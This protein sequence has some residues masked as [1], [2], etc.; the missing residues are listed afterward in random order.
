MR[1]HVRGKERYF[2]TN[3]GDLALDW[4]SNGADYTVLD[5]SYVAKC[6]SGLRKLYGQIHRNADGRTYDAWDIKAGRRRVKT[7]GSETIEAAIRA[8]VEAETGVRAYDLTVKGKMPL[9]PNTIR[10]EMCHVMK[11]AIKGWDFCWQ[12][13]AKGWSEEQKEAARKTF[14]EMSWNSGAYYCDSAEYRGREA[15]TIGLLNVD[16]GQYGELYKRWRGACVHDS[17]PTES[18]R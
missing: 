3:A 4:G 17:Y 9:V 10:T 6:P 18:A 15:K 5:F 13:E 14:I 7:Q 12:G 8:Y 16:V 1:E 11:E 2:R